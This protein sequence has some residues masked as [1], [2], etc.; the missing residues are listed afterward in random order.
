[1][2]LVP[3]RREG[4]FIYDINGKKYLNMHCNGGVFNLGHRNPRIIQAVKVAMDQYDIGN[5]HLISEPKANLAKRLVS[6]LPKGLEHVVF[7]VSGGEAI[8]LAIKLARAATGKKKIISAA[9]GYH[10]HTGFALSTGDDRFKAPFEPLIP[11]CI[12][13]PFNDISALES[14]VDE[15]TATVILETIPATL[16]MI[17]PARLYIEKVREL[18]TKFGAIFII[19]EVQTGLGRTGKIWAIEH[20][21]INPDILVTGKGLSGGIY[22]IT[23]TCITSQINQFLTE[24]PFIHVSTFGGSEIGCFAALEVLNILTEQ[25]FLDRVNQKAEKLRTGLEGIQEKYKDNFL[26]IRQLGLFMGLKFRDPVFTLVLVKV[27][28]D[29]GIYTVYSANDKR[30]L[31]FLPPLTI[32]D[33]EINIVLSTLENSL[34]QLNRN[35]KYRALYFLAE[36]MVREPV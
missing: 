25:G 17:V 2:A 29:N 7:G 11:E 32:T 6:T 14:A 36:K 35:L 27:L 20:F 30:V 28:F 10:G 1:V 34:N 5:H 18:C 33:E 31:Q 3:H 13:V 4:T 12:Q 22:P 8:D 16:G 15:D 26:E 23:A 19:D 24:N 9:G 21:G